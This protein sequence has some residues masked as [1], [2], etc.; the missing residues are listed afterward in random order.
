MWQEAD[1]VA[2]AGS[3]AAAVV[4]AAASQSQKHDSF[5]AIGNYLGSFKTLF[6]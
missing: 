5:P 3:A 2:V 4:V 1:D 6:T